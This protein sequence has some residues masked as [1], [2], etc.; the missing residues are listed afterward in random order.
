MTDHKKA[1]GPARV[2][3]DGSYGKFFIGDALI[4]SFSIAKDVVDVIYRIEISFSIVAE[5]EEVVNRI[6]AS[7]AKDFVPIEKFKELQKLIELLC[8]DKPCEKCGAPVSFECYGCKLKKS[9]EDYDRLKEVV[10][11]LAKAAAIIVSRWNTNGLGP[12][13]EKRINFL[14]DALS[15]FEALESKNRPIS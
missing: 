2:E 1:N 8:S 4:C 12:G 15:E 6:N 14:E 9:Q 5:A 7:I 3:M 10:Y 11:K 13:D